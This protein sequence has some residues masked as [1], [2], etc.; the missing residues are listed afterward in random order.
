MFTCSILE[1]E[2]LFEGIHS[3]FIN[4]FSYNKSF[5]GCIAKTKD[6]VG[7]HFD[8]SNGCIYYCTKIFESDISIT[9]WT[10]FTY[11][12]ALSPDKINGEFA[13]KLFNIFKKHGYINSLEQFSNN[14]GKLK[15]SK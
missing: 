10:L 4:E 15:L 14:L 1:K 12:W 5:N 11:K 6:S 7:W 13:H 2:L 9:D 8:Y 3:E